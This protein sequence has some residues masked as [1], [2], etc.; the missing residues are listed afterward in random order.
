MSVPITPIIDFSDVKTYDMIQTT[1]VAARPVP[2]KTSIEAIYDTFLS[3]RIIRRKKLACE[4]RWHPYPK[5]IV[6]EY[7][8]VYE[9][10]SEYSLAPKYRTILCYSEHQA[11][12]E[13]FRIYRGAKPIK[14]CILFVRHE[15]QGSMA[16]VKRFTNSFS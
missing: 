3:K 5:Y 13:L 2:E 8:T 9:Y 16:C 12:G 6:H 4:A 14:E 11:V 15:K 1:I 7:E 10:L